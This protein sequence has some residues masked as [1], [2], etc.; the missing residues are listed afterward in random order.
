MLMFQGQGLH[1]VIV[2]DTS[3]EEKFRELSNAFSQYYYYYYY[4]QYNFIV[5]QSSKF[6]LI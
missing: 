3:S 1:N 4:Y 2:H 5:C 6:F